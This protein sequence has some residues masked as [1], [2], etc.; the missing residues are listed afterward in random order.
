MLN[1]YV[2]RSNSS[3]G[4]SAQRNEHT[5][6]PAKN[7][8]GIVYCGGQEKQAHKYK[9]NTLEDAQWTGLQVLLELDVIGVSEH[10][11]TEKET[12]CINETL[13]H[14]CNHDWKSPVSG[15]KARSAYPANS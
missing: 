15:W 6:D 8:S 10:T 4:H 12:G 2:P 13:G 3:T 1:P 9:G 5:V 14:C 7:I 11:G